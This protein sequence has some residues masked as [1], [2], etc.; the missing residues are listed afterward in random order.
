MP[1][2]SAPVMPDYQQVHDVIVIDGVGQG[3]VRASASLRAA[4]QARF[5]SG[6]VTSPAYVGE[7]HGN[8]ENHSVSLNDTRDWAGEWFGL[9]TDGSGTAAITSDY[10][11]YGQV[12]YT[13]GHGSR[14][15]T[16]S[17]LA[18]RTLRALL[19][20]MSQ[21]GMRPMLDDAVLVP[22]LASGSNLFAT[23]ASH[24]T[25]AR[26]VF[27]L[28]YGAMLICGTDGLAIVDRPQ[29]TSTGSDSGSALEWSSKVL[30]RTASLG[31]P[32]QLNLSGGKDSRAV[33][34]LLLANGLSSK[35]QVHTSGGATAQPAATREILDA[36]LRLSATLVERYDLKWQDRSPFEELVI[37]NRRYLEY[38]QDYRSGSSFEYRGHRSMIRSEPLVEITGIGGELLRS[39]TGA[40]Y[41]S[42]YPG[43]WA[44]AGKTSESVRTDLALL[45]DVLVRPDDIEEAI[46]SAARDA[47]IESF[48]LGA[49]GDVISQID[50][51]YLEYRN[52]AHAGVHA[53][54]SV[55]GQNLVYPLASPYLVAFSEKLAESRPTASEEGLALFEIIEALEPD[56]NQL[57]YASPP[58]PNHFSPRSNFDWSAVDP[59]GALRRRSIV[60]NPPRRTRLAEGDDFSL[61]NRLFQTAAVLESQNVDGGTLRRA[62]RL[63]QRSSRLENVVLAVMESALDVLEVRD[64]PIRTHACDLGELNREPSNPEVVDWRVFSQE[65][66]LTDLSAVSLTITQIP[67]AADGLHVKIDVVDLPQAC[68]VACYFYAD[69][70]RVQ[71]DWY[72]AEPVFT[73][74]FAEV[75]RSMRAQVFLRWRGN[76]EAHRVIDTSISPRQ[77]VEGDDDDGRLGLAIV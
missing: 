25:L 17:L 48:D 62:A 49:T 45:F 63:A 53:Y 4:L 75:P 56:L 14:P 43:W 38:W 69:G 67:T 9:F 10:F 23:R 6:W 76:S 41:R 12:F 39:Y 34:G 65:W 27:V 42:N 70:D 47:F 46:H 44:K 74:D 1:H 36:D 58:W 11:G 5:L 15:G 2:E 68:D 37:G 61:R 3:F 24:R 35:A 64:V 71:T 28:P 51:S 26:E 55:Q 30:D 73:V 50:R 7:I 20:A 22:H 77:Y 31:L 66:A 52:R 54:R 8:L 13:L 57:P 40:P 21:R 72:R 16:R 59:S 29:V 32:L 18:A 33:L 19:T 60:G